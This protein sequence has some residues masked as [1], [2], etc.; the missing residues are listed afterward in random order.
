MGDPLTWK[1]MVNLAEKG[2]SAIEDGTATEETE[3]QRGARVIAKRNFGA[4][5]EREAPTFLDPAL[6]P[7]LGGF[8]FRRPPT[9]GSA[10]KGWWRL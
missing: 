7:M 3:S 8:S 10:S 4:I 2:W 9:L 1:H 5:I 6:T